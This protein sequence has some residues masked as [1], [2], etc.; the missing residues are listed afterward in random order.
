MEAANNSK[1]SNIVDLTSLPKNLSTASD[2]S[3][4]GRNT[5]SRDSDIPPNTENAVAFRKKKASSILLIPEVVGPTKKLV[6]SAA[7]GRSSLPRVIAA[8]LAVAFNLLKACPAVSSILPKASSVAPDL[9]SISSM[10]SVK[11]PA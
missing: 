6:R 7:A 9:F 11:D 10:I 3:T 8:T 1:S 2:T 5:L 4:I